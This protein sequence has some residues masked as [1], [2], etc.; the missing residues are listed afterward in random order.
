MTSTL[1]LNLNLKQ[2]QRTIVLSLSLLSGLT[3]GFCLAVAPIMHY[4]YD[5]NGN[6]TKTTDGLSHATTQQYDAVDRLIQQSQPHPTTPNTQLGKTAT[7][8]NAVD[9]VT[10]IT[11]PR[12]L[13]TQ[14]TKNAFGEVLSQAS[15]DTGTTRSTYDNAGNL[16]TRTDARNK[17]LTYT[18]DSLNRLVKMVYDT[19][20]SVSFAYDQGVNG[21][22]HLT[23]MRDTT[24]TTSWTYNA[25]GRVLSKTWATGTIKL[26]TRC[27]YDT[28]GRLITMTYPSGK[29]VN[30]TY[31]KGLV[32]ALTMSGQVLVNAIH[33]QPFGTAADWVYGNGLKAI[34]DFD[35]DGRI[36]AYDLGERVRTVSYDAASRIAKY[37]DTDLN[38][39]QTF[40]HDGLD[41][42]VA[43]DTPRSQTDLSYDLNGNRTQLLVNGTS[44][45]SSIATTNNRLLKISQNTTALKTYSYDLAGNITSDGSNQ[46]AY[47]GR[48]RL[49]SATGRFNGTDTYKINGLGQRITKINGSITYFVYDEAGQLLGEYD[50]SGKAIQETV[51]LGNMP[52]ALIKNN[53]RYYIYADHL[54]TPR[55]IADG[56]G[57]VIW[58]W[59]GEP[60]GSTL[61]N[62]DPDKNSQKFTYNLRFPGQYYDNS[63]GL[64]YNGFR[65]YDPAIGR[66]IES[67]PIGLAGGINT[68]AYVGGNPLSYTDPQGLA[69]SG[70]AVGGQ[71]GGYV[72][73]VVG[74]AIGGLVGPEGI[75]VGAAAGRAAGSAAGA[76][77]AGSAIQDACSPDKPCPP[78]SPYPVGQVGYQGPKQS[79]F[80]IDGTRSGTG[81]LHY[82]IFEVQQNPFDQCKC[83]WQET[84]K[85]FGHHFYGNPDP[86]WINLN[87]KGRPPTYP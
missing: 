15:P 83:R 68:Y 21:L 59:D 75:P 12:L 27:G 73:G 33:Y 51:W 61:A 4:E 3:P 42:L 86:L 52:V 2:H 44:K 65:D 19:N 11:D 26:I 85:L 70:A 25:A 71:V 45:T 23:L 49:V 1:R 14:Y 74:G 43:V 60:F 16:L 29:T 81:K 76:A 39:D 47:D 28:A 5:A 77:A 20:V 6:L 34:R 24:G 63:T 13:A 54:N 17:T 87:G 7:K 36:I 18:Y 31:S 32:S 22:G 66:Y 78:C 58:R 69:A 57:K 80:G 10:A 40:V 82:I 53:A 9:E 50:T 72:G 48:G 46:F 55:A 30:V 8:Y 84:K 62:E 79:V 41:R 35:L 38:Y 64:H 37:K 67:D 56:V